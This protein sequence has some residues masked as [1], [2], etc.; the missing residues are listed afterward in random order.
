MTYGHGNSIILLVAEKM[1]LE[2]SLT[3]AAKRHLRGEETHPMTG[4]AIER[5]A[6]RMNDL[7]KH[8]A[9]LIA[10]ANGL[11]EGLKVEYGFTA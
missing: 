10:Q 8:D 2:P 3:D 6:E 1:G 9:S 7:L 5:E 11:A 4:A